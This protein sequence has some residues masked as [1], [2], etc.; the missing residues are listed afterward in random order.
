VP[1]LG[2][3]AQRIVEDVDSRISFS[4]DHQ[5]FAFMRG[6]PQQQTSYLM[7]A[8]ADGSDVKTLATQGGI[9]QF[10]LTGPSWSPDGRTIVASMQSLE[11][12]PH[13]LM[14]AVD[15]ATGEIRK[16]PNRWTNV[17]DLHWLPDGRSFVAVASEFG[18][19]QSQLWE[20][21]YPG[22][23]ANR[24]TTDLN[25]YA[26][27]SLSADAS[28]LVTVQV[29]NVSHLWVGPAEDAAP[30]TP[31]TRGRNRSDGIGGFDWT[32]DG[33]LVFASNASGSPQI[34]I[35]N[36]DGTNERQLTTGRA[37]NMEPSAT[38]DGRYIVFL[39]FSGTGAH[40]W[41]MNS[42]G[43]DQKPITTSGTFF[44]PR[45]APDG[46]VYMNAVHTG[47][48][49]PWKVP[50]EGGE[51]TL[52]VDDYFRPVDV[53]PDGR[54]LLGVGWDTAAR[55]STAAVL[56]LDTGKTELIPNIPTFGLTW[57][58]DGRSLAFWLPQNQSVQVMKATP[59]RAPEPI[60]TVEDNVYTMGWSPDG[61][62]LAMARGQGLS[63]VIVI[64]PK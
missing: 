37:P 54:R 23:Q 34:W 41:R 44:T 63:D 33:R 55:R 45:A 35:V 25:T 42:D 18:S 4:P 14:A 32:A 43:S 39:R 3:T 36:A 40:V 6:A 29:E 26:A 57:H 9:E 56:S 13:G 46:F 31:I 30:A 21:S 22:G 51:P 2:G 24:I 38:P 11:G 59:G 50:I 7:T 53:S 1:V 60:V 52:I 19:I 64:T 17:N 58:P 49:R 48:P 20:I 16:L 28:A 47:S 27:V 8:K 62:R 12:G 61:K 10:G 15:A 5:Q